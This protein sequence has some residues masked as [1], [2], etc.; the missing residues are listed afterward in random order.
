V[1]TVGTVTSLYTTG[2]HYAAAYTFNESIRTYQQTGSIDSAEPIVI[3]AYGLGSSDAYAR[4]V[5]EFQLTRIGNMLQMPSPTVED[6]ESFRRI[7]VDGINVAEQAVDADPSESANWGVLGG[8]YSILQGANME[9]VYERGVEALTRARDLNPKNPITY[10][11]LAI[12]DV[13]A[14]KYDSA[15]GYAEQAIALKPDYT[16]AFFYLSQIDIVTGNVDGAI[17][18]TLSIIGLEPQN[19][20]RYYQLG[21]LYIS[22]ND[23]DS[24]QSS[25]ENAVSLDEN[26]ANARYFLALVYDAKGRRDDARVQ[27]EKVLEL[28]PGNAEVM[29]LLDALRSGKRLTGA[30]V[31][32][33]ETQPV[34]DPDANVQ[35]E[36][37]TVTTN[38]APNTP[39]V[40]PVNT[41]PTGGQA[42]ETQQG[43][44]E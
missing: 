26:Y 27:L 18:S 42:P 3:R 16:D 5:A 38:E 8:F 41:A 2:R 24:A 31:T 21:V 30:Q 23:L 13:R 9:G 22:K 4:R 6:Q 12:L 1:I 33:P 44:N 28:N 29:G 39:L 34:T 37:G 17:K 40:A 43:S 35:V 7:I 14:G 25:F 19:P 36:N 32:T 10:L 11:E 20:A 15:R